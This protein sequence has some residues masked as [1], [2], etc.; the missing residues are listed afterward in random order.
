MSRTEQNKGLKITLHFDICSCVLIE[1]LIGLALVHTSLLLY[2]C[3]TGI[4]FLKLIVTCTILNMY[5]V[6]KH[7]NQTSNCLEV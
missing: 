2:R 4:I 1:N 7:L 3:M 6:K 5:D